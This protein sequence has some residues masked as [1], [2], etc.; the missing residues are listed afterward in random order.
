MWYGPACLQP[1][2]LVSLMLNGYTAPATN[3]TSQKFRIL[4]TLTQE[5]AGAIM[6]LA[7]TPVMNVTSITSPTTLSASSSSQEERIQHLQH[8]RQKLQRVSSSTPNLQTGSSSSYALQASQSDDE[9]YDVLTKQINPLDIIAAPPSS[10][11]QPRSYAVLNITQSKS[12][13]VSQ[14]VTYIT[15][16]IQNPTQYGLDSSIMNRFTAQDYIQTGGTVDSVTT[17]APSSADASGPSV[18]IIVIAIA[19]PVLLIIVA[20]LV[21]RKY[22]QRQAQASASAANLYE[23]EAPQSDFIGSRGGN[24][25]PFNSGS[26]SQNMIQLSSQNNASSVPP[27]RPVYATAQQNSLQQKFVQQTQPQPQPR[28]FVPQQQFNSVQTQYAPAIAPRPVVKPAG[29][30]LPPNWIQCFNDTGIPYY[31]NT[32]TQES[33]WEIPKK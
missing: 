10:S 9:A 6:L 23:S 19:V 31:W 1:N 22:K 18:L 7:K 32:V 4:T 13:T 26:G 3:N 8:L 5:L 12:F 20:F 15:Q 2:I 24:F 28:Q 30:V 25:V 33:T 21:Y 11:G 16:V 27:A 14:L 29:P 17:N